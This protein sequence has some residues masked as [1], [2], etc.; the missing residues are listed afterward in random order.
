[1]K[2]AKITVIGAGNVGATCAQYCAMAGLGDVYLLDIPVT[3]DMP[4]G[5]A[6]DIT[7]AAPVLFSLRG[8]IFCSRRSFLPKSVIR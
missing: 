4:K 5:K 1:M 8:L 6:L 7:E 2:R 3:K